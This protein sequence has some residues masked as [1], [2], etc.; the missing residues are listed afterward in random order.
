MR[1][2]MFE[3][4]LCLILLGFILL[5]VTLIKYLID[6]LRIIPKFSVRVQVDQEIFL[7]VL[8]PNLTV[9]WLEDH[10]AERYF[11][12]T[13]VKVTVKIRDGSGAKMFSEDIL[14]NMVS[15]GDQLRTD[16]TVKPI[17]EEMSDS[18]YSG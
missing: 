5:V 4:L 11:I 13:G 18:K 12:E 17:D 10:V 2:I 14:W 9:S 7:V 8:Y 6:Q 15:N 3:A 1:F 16:V